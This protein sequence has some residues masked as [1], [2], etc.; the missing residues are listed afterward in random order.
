MAFLNVRDSG[1]KISNA[2]K[3]MRIQKFNLFPKNMMEALLP[4]PVLNIIL[5]H[6]RRL[7]RVHKSFPWTRVKTNKQKSPCEKTQLKKRDTH[8]LNS[9]FP[10]NSP[11]RPALESSALIRG[12]DNSIWWGEHSNI[13]GEPR[14]QR[15]SGALLRLK[16]R[17]HL[18]SLGVTE[19]GGEKRLG[20]QAVVLLVSGVIAGVTS[21]PECK[22]NW[23]MVDGLRGYPGLIFLAGGS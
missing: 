3:V 10:T 20:S 17:S 4:H 12:S 23:Q 2:G 18:Y 5:V 16:G 21:G 13:N 14:E 6:K 15:S 22:S 11:L 7:V 19:K 8:G 9:S 1:T